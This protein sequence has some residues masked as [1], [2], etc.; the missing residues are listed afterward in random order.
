MLKKYTY[1]FNTVL[2]RMFYVVIYNLMKSF[3][4]CLWKT[5]YPR[6]AKIM[7][8]RVEFKNITRN[9]NQLNIILTRLISYYVWE[10][11]K[12]WKH[13]IEDYIFDYVILKQNVQR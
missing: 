12:G 8:Q 1:A 5:T 4:Q 3:H 2:S 11:L 9:I 7:K 10:L 13:R 6:I